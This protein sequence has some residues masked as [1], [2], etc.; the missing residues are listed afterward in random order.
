MAFNLSIDEG[1]FVC[2]GTESDVKAVGGGI[3]DFGSALGAIM[4]VNLSIGE[5]RVVRP[6]TELGVGAVGGGVDDFGSA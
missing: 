5:G 1:R 6:G 3:D 4:A 2:P